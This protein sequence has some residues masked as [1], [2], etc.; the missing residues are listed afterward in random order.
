MTDDELAK[1]IYKYGDRVAL[2]GFCRQ[3][4]TTPGGEDN[5]RAK[6]STVLQRL[7]DKLKIR[8]KE[9]GNDTVLLNKAGIG[10]NNASKGA[11]RLEMGWL[12]FQNGEYHQV[13][14]KHGGGTRH[15]AVDKQFTV[16]KLTGVGK[17]LFFPKG[18][19]PKGP[20]E[21]FDFEI[22]DF[23]QAAVSLKSTVSELYDTSKIRMLRLYICTMEAS[24]SISPPHVIS[25]E[26][27]SDFL[28]DQ[29]T[30]DK[31]RKVIYT[32]HLSLE[33][34]CMFA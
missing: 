31:R 22:R 33:R 25:S 30:Q 8:S 27:S 9:P 20:A 2:R 16:E 18:I 7:K 12:N 10:N 15:L 14:T 21:N 13:R 26:T 6:R 32:C 1:Y 4:Q 5:I 24:K 17:E 3:K 29:S 34:T 28:P 19:S 23:S 11:R